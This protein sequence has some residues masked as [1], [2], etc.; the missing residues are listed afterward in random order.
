MK[1]ALVGEYSGVHT[2]L[3]IGLE[4]IGHEATT[5][6]GGDGFK[7][8]RPDRLNRIPLGQLAR[9]HQL[10]VGQPRLLSDLASNYDVIQFI[11]PTALVLPRFVPRASYAQWLLSFLDSFRG[12][13][14]MAVAGCDSYVQPVMAASRFCPCAGCLKD[15]RRSICAYDFDTAPERGV[16]D[17]LTGR[18][19]CFI[20]FASA[21]YADAYAS[22]SGGSNGPFN[23][24]VELSNPAL[25][26]RRSGP[27]RVLHG[28]IRPGF[29]G[30]DV[31]LPVL[32]ALVDRHPGRYELVIAERLPYAEYARLLSTVNVVV[33]QLYG[34]GLGM[35]AL[36]AMARGRVLL[37]SFDRS[38]VRGSVDYRDTPA[39]DI[40]HGEEAILSALEAIQGLSADELARA[41]SASREYVEA[42]CAPAEVARQLCAVWSRFQKTSIK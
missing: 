17:A 38:F 34:G 9:A 1:I 42:R 5:I 18:V 27:L 28:I 29:K 24:P 23:F 8:F 7:R 41:G 6:S 26:N 3:K 22:R 25:P 36:G 16:T 40:S 37:T 15:S 21:A 10:F 11:S 20:P 13:L 2:N 14:S 30:T 4:Q 19:H 12:V 33:D 39:Y 32:R 31:I 35:N